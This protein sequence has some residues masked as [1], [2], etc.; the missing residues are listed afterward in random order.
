MDVSTFLK[1]ASIVLREAWQRKF[2]CVLI[3]FV[4]SMLVLV[5]GMFWP[6]KFE[7]S[8]TIFADNQNILKPLLEKQAAQGKVQDQSRIVRDVMHSPRILQKVVEQTMDMSEFESAQDMGAAING[9]RSRLLIQGLGSSYIK[10]SYTDSEP[11]QAYDV[12]NKVTDL[13]IQDS[14]EGQRSESREAFMFIDNQVRQ[15][16]EQLLLAEEKLKQF[17]SANFDGRDSDVDGSIARIRNEIESLKISIDEDKTKISALEKQLASESE[18]SNQKFKADVYSDRL[19]ELESRL[20]TMLLSYRENH[21][22]VVTLKYQIEDVKNTIM[23][24]KN[25]T[26]RDQD[27]DLSLNPLYQELRS[28][29]SNAQVEMGAKQRRLD[30]LGGLL[31]KEYE[32]RKRIAERAAEEAELTRDYNVTKNIYED[33]LER[34]EKARLS[35]TLN[36]EGQGVSYRVQEPAIYPLNPKGLTFVHFVILGPIFGLCS[37]I[38]IFLAYIILDRRIRD[39]EALQAFDGVKTL[40]VIPHILTPLPRRIFKADMVMFVLFGIAVMACYVFVAYATKMGML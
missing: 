26:K 30:A 24:A 1:Y 2:L 34:K 4:S 31:E 16:K 13:F 15:Y 10:V 17:R 40:A 7:V 5:V 23:E 36:I 11:E 20:N 6:V 18:F 32:R 19:M 39:P 27:E 14:S 29:L 8:T 22:D 33:M 12:I 21:P 9:I 35:M 38:G 37:I 28:R 25:D 3:F